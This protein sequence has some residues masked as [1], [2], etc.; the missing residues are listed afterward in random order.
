MFAGGFVGNRCVG[1]N[2]VDF[3]LLGLVS[4]VKLFKVFVLSNHIF[5]QLYCSPT[6]RLELDM[7]CMARIVLFSSV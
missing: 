5:S 3:V 7:F 6:C 1:V 4:V 2:V